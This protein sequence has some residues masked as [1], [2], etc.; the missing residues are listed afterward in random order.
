MNTDVQTALPQGDERPDGMALRHA[1]IE[2]DRAARLALA[3]ELVGAITHD[4]RQPLTAVEMNVAAALHLL[5]RPTPRVDEAIQALADAQ[6]QQRRMSDA[7]QVLQDLAVRREPFLETVDAVSIV[8]EVVRLV[9]TDAIARH[10]PIELEILPPIPHVRGEAMLMRQGLLNVLL[11]ALEATSLSASR[12]SPVRVVVRHA[13]GIV[14]IKVT[15]FGERAD[16]A[17]I[18]EWGLAVARLEFVPRR[19]TRALPSRAIPRAV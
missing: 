18:E 12:T 14:E 7:V 6:E 8:R 15:H 2:L 11:N 19:I 3:G 5:R 13:D 16:P 1:R 10:V 17:I 4:L 9:G